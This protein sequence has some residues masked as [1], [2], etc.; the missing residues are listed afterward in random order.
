MI[1][2][3]A[4]AFL[5]GFLFRVKCLIIMFIDLIVDLYNPYIASIV[6]IIINFYV[7]IL[8]Q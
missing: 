4:V 6:D 1:I 7:S 5:Y 3:R 8:L 2:L